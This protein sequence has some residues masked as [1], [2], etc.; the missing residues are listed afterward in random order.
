MPDNERD[1]RKD[2]NE[3]Y[4]V[5]YSHWGPYLQYAQ[6][7]MEFEAGKQYNEM[8]RQYLLG[9]G[10][11][12]LVF[13]KVRRVKNLISG[14]QRKNRMALRI[15]PT[16]GSDE[17]TA[18][19]LS[20]V[21]MRTMTNSNG[22]HILSDAFE[23]G[24]IVAGINLVY[25]YLDYFDD[26]L[27]GD[28]KLARQPFNKFLMDPNWSDL[29]FKD[30]K[31]LL[32]REYLDPKDIKAI[33][34]AGSRNVVSSIKAGGRDEKFP[35]FM[36]HRSYNANDHWRYDEF[37]T[38]ER[39]A[40]TI[41]FDPVKM[42]MGIWKG[43]RDRMRYLMQQFPNLR[44]LKT[45]RDTV[46]LNILVEDRWVYSGPAPQ[47]I[48]EYP[49]V[50][51]IGYFTPEQKESQLKLQ[52]VIRDIIDP[53]TEINKR[54]SKMLDIIDSQIS[55]GWE[56][57]EDTLV[58]P[59][60][61]YQ[62]GQSQVIWK[63]KTARDFPPT[64]IPPG[65]IP[66]G[67]FQLNELFEKDVYEIPGANNELFGM[68]DQENAEV[69]SMLAKQRQGAGLTTLQGL[70]DNY[71]LS[72]KFLGIKI[73][74]MIQKN[75]SPQKVARIIEQ[76]PSAEFFAGSFGKYDCTPVEG[77]LS[78]S[79]R[80]MHYAQLFALKVAGAPIPWAAI[81]D[82]APIEK[83]D[84]LKKMMAEQEKAQQ[85]MQQQQQM[86]AQLETMLK[87]A[88]LK[89]DLAGAAEKATQA[90]ENRAGAV[91]DRVK[92]LKELEGVEVDQ[93]V[94]LAQLINTLK[95]DEQIAPA[96]GAAGSAGPPATFQR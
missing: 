82:A 65:D 30:C 70:F 17:Q 89:S 11:E 64:K 75:Y 4:S 41:I 31:F 32:R 86:L 13:N 1:I 28:I 26:P 7:D 91:L 56:V 49:W 66:P 68:P 35:Y 92:T 45:T 52:G 61:V 22:Y 44:V 33:L 40:V 59:E 6:R 14:Y 81:V 2:F 95:M 36:P 74:K 73:V 80:Q 63:K 16:G 20:G 39:M 38:K 9:Q 71:R 76:R 51:I 84:D 50:P 87:Q 15:D 79:Q 78:D 29:T 88:K 54:R 93:L 12:V 42:E 8:Y 10:R 55:N 67:L 57:F 72:K 69:A 21:T 24:A 27:D 47:G 77:V 90:Q 58:D 5:A 53:Q 43:S 62:S 37:W 85:G 19:Q 3:A 83:K 96:A 23:K 48:D 34:P 25:L 46:K 94:K 60:S 18:S